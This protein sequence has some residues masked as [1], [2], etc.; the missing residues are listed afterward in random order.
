MAEAITQRTQKFT[1][2]PYQM[3][4]CPGA[5]MTTAKSRKPLEVGEVNSK[6]EPKRLRKNSSPSIWSNKRGFKHAESISGLCFVLTLLFDRFLA[7]F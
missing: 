5:I 4:L 1:K 7:T 2:S 6:F 3:K